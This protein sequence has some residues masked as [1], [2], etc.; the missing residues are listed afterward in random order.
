[1]DQNTLTCAYNELILSHFE[2]CCE[3]WYTIGVN[4]SDHLEKLQNG[5]VRVIIGRKS[6]RRRFELALNELNF[7]TLK[8]R[9]TRF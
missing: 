6:E 3:V 7:K 9:R 4:L 2:Y 5:D 1:M 8:E